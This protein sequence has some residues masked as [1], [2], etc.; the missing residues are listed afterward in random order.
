M[1]TRN[2]GLDASGIEPCKLGRFRLLMTAVAWLFRRRAQGP[3]NRV[4]HLDAHGLKDIGL[5]T[6][7]AART[8]SAARADAFRLLMMRGNL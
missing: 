1:Q 2:Q 8:T 5:D 6:Q 7:D 3:V 4:D